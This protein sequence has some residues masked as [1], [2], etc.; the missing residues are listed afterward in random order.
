MCG[1]CGIIQPQ[2]SEIDRDMLVRMCDSL[3]HRGPDAEGL[4]I[5]E[6]VGLGHRR[7]KIID[8]SEGGAQPMFNEDNTVVVVFNGEIYNFQPIKKELEKKGHKFRSRC[9]TEVIIHGYEEWGAQCLD[10]FNGMFAFVLY[11]KKRR[12]VFMAR[13]RLGIKPLYYYAGPRGIL[14][15]SESRAFFQCDTFSPALE[16]QAL[17]EYLLFRSLA[18]DGTMLRGVKTLLPGHWL[19]I[20]ADLSIEIKQYWNIQF[21]APPMDDDFTSQEQIVSELLKESVAMQELSDVPI[22]AQLSGGTDSSLVTALMAERTSLPIKTFSVGFDEQGFNEL[23]YSTRVAR[24]LRTE[25][26]AI[27]LTNEDFSDALDRLSWQ[28]GE[29]MTHANSAGIYWICRDAKRTVTVLL[30]G[31]GADE[32][33][34]GYYRYEWLRKCFKARRWLTPIAPLLPVNPRNR[35]LASLWKALSGS[36]SDLIVKSTAAGYESFGSLLDQSAQRSVFDSRTEFLAHAR[37]Q[38]WLSQALYYDLKTYLVPILMRQDKMSMAFGVETRV[39]FLDHRL[40]ELAFRLPSKSKLLPG[41]SKRIIKQIAMRYVPA[42]VIYRPKQG[43]AFPLE[44]WMRS[45]QGLGERLSIITDDNSLA[46]QLFPKKVLTDLVEQHR[47]GAR[48]HTD[49]LWTLLSLE[50]WR[51][52]FLPGPIVLKEH[53]S[54]ATTHAEPSKPAIAH[55]VLNLK[56]GGLERVVVN[57]VRG[58]RD[59]PYN[60]V[61][62]CLESRG[63]FADD[64][65]RLGVPLHVFYK[66]A[67][68]DWNVILHLAH[69]FREHNVK[70]VHTHNPGPHFHGMI[71]AWLVGVPVRVHTRHGRNFPDDKKQVAINRIL[72][73]GTDVIVPVSDDAGKVA[74]EVEH[75]NPRKVHR[76]WN[77]IDV[78]LYQPAD[79]PSA[80]PPVIGTV[81]R[82]SPEK[83]QKTMLAA[84]RHVLDSIPEARLIL[85]GDGPSAQELH[86]TAAKL[87]INGQVDFLGQRS[88]IPEVL[89]RMSV[90]TLSSTTEGL[91]MTVLEAMAAGLPVVATDVGGN[92]ELI[93]PPECGV[94]VPARDPQALAKAYVE[95]LHDRK[96]RAQM[97]IAA[98]ARAVRFFSLEHTVSEYANLYD[99]LMKRKVGR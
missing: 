21:D 36:P 46:S 1:I 39:P 15:A 92:R 86:D 68:L 17:N 2:G 35:Q 56:V 18:G 41:E 81:A 5:H 90:F 80:R 3:L 76:I 58:F 22:G 9:D 61:V 83:D 7:L 72:S 96:Q 74:T 66:K 33:F 29:P 93:N 79:E 43:F 97:S 60:C 30:T 23:D 63:E 48:N 38:S 62:C 85:V 28:M 10:R 26:H 82:L 27:I 77:G 73:W 32:T 16:D 31:E 98:R 84:F 19:R 51:Q 94:V 75:V 71:A 45:R 95:V 65:D 20:R 52:Q 37:N 40:V 55:V 59:S 89:R 57:L 24:H 50:T 12:E 11:D 6:N 69:F 64:I 25:H 53:P 88:D 42:E 34:A 47:S 91:S 8:L 54:I 70:I 87:G 14:F 13:D 78:D 4:Y 44:P 67:G 99:E 49:A